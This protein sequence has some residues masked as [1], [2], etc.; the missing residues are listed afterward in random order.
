ME[1]LKTVKRKSFLSEVTYIFLNVG[2][3]I[4]L[5]ITVRVTG[6]MWL[7]FALVL[8][9]RWRVFAVRARYWFANIQAD[10]VSLI[11]SLSFVVFLYNANISKA[12]ES[13]ILWLQIGLTVLY[14]IWLLIIKQL[15]KRKYV[16]LQAGIALFV[17]VSAIYTLS[18]SWIATPV[19]LLMW[20]IGYAVSR[21]VLNTYDEEHHIILLSLVCGFIAAEVGWIAYHWTIA[22]RLP[23]LADI[24]IPRVSILMLCF[25]FLAYKCYDSFYH[26][27]KIRMVDIIMPLLFCVSLVT[28]LLVAFNGLP[29]DIVN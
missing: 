20:L 24:T 26:H 7:A 14:S 2:L 25:G 16:A 10:L 27:D 18:Y 6:S 11:I 9:S 23:V 4:L 5:M 17:G 19:I 15:S 3:A 12:G 8:L 22:Y 21:H 29:S 1:F 13:N 28:V